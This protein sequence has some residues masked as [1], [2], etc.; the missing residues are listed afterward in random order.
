MENIREIL[1]KSTK[2][3][4]GKVL[5]ILKAINQEIRANP[6]IHGEFSV[7]IGSA[8][9]YV[10]EN[11]NSETQDVIQHGDLYLHL[12]S[13]EKKLFKVGD[14]NCREFVSFFDSLG[15]LKHGRHFLESEIISINLHKDSYEKICK[16]IEDVIEY[17][18]KRYGY[19]EKLI[20]V[21]EEGE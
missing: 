17:C 19:N 1:N 10:K 6:N 13:D 9:I 21:F 15:R 3:N 18:N 11:E 4:T 2:N 8:Y 16:K 14:Y 5:E 7:W 20:S 12:N